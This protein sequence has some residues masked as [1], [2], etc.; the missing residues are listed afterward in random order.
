M[1]EGGA[2][3]LVSSGV[4][5]NNATKGGGIAVNGKV[6]LIDTPMI[7]NEASVVCVSH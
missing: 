4:K 5:F 7:R 3:K 2:V 6:D 1:H